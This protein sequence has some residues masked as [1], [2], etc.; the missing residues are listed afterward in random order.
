MPRTLTDIFNDNRDVEVIEMV[1][2]ND[3]GPFG[4]S[5]DGRKLK[6]LDNN[7]A[8]QLAGLPGSNTEAG[9][10]SDEGYCIRGGYVIDADSHKASVHRPDPRI[11]KRSG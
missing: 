3:G 2:Y 9:H 5:S 1:G 11:A 6:I 7:F 10:I 4:L 8:R